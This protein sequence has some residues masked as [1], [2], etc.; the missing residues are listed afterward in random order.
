[1]SHWRLELWVKSKMVWFLPPHHNN[2]EENSAVAA[3]SHVH[4]RMLSLAN[5]LKHLKK[6]KAATFAH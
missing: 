5:S 6:Q 1:M 2:I 4:P 3:E